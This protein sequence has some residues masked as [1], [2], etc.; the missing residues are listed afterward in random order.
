M[1]R[2]IAHG[3]AT[4]S[5]LMFSRVIHRMDVPFFNGYCLVAA[6]AFAL[7]VSLTAALKPVANFS[8]G[9]VPQ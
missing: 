3:H 8:A 1:N 9:P 4:R 6:G 7:A 5:T 2:L